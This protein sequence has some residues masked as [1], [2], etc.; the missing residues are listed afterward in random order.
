MLYKV[1]KCCSVQRAVSAQVQ[2]S[3]VEGEEIMRDPEQGVCGLRWRMKMSCVTY[4]SVIS[5]LKL[6]ETLRRDRLWHPKQTP[7][8]PPVPVPLPLGSTEGD[9][10]VQSST[11]MDPVYTRISCHWIL[12]LFA[13]FILVLIKVFLHHLFFQLF[14][15]TFSDPE[16]FSG[17]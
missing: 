7:S 15:H 11:P 13:E 14:S 12:T 17:S 2:E 1:L 10:P 5:Y 4:M 3:L 6:P 16:R 8:L 9:V